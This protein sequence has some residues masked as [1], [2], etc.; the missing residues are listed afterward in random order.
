[1]Q[2]KANLGG[3]STAWTIVVD[4][5]R[6][7]LDRDAVAGINLGKNNR[8][9]DAGSVI[10]TPGPERVGASRL[11]MHIAAADPDADG[12]VH[13]PPLTGQTPV[14][15][16]ERV[17][18]Y[19]QAEPALRLRMAI[20]ETP[21]AHPERLVDIERELKLLAEHTKEQRPGPPPD[22]MVTP[23]WAAARTEQAE[24]V[25]RRAARTALDHYT[26][27]MA[28]RHGGRRTRYELATLF[29]RATAENSAGALST[30]TCKSLLALL[31]PAGDAE[32]VAE[33]P[34]RRL[35][36]TTL[37]DLASISEPELA[38]ATPTC[39][40]ATRPSHGPRWYAASSRPTVAA[41]APSRDRSCTRT[42]RTTCPSVRSQSPA[43]RSRLAPPPAPRAR[44][45]SGSTPTTSHC[46]SRWAAPTAPTSTSATTSPAT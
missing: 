12:P 19:V 22:C 31:T 9:I 36:E 13:L 17:D 4:R 5:V 46:A 35:H 6:G 2:I 18:R 3:F 37:T 10:V 23:T 21:P 1:M 45:W 7:G 27:A 43:T 41:A 14:D 39:G 40:C 26:L 34:P 16:I 28:L 44:R 25:R 24:L 33:R 30:E 42:G 11:E 20:G 15:F 8:A 38:A 32:P 29:E